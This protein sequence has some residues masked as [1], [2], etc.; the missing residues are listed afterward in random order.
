MKYQKASASAA[1]PAT[2]PTTAP[3]MGPVFEGDE[4]G[5]GADVRSEAGDEVCLADAEAR[6]GADVCDVEAWVDTIFPSSMNFP[7]PSLQQSV[8][9]SEVPQ[10]RT[11]S[12]QVV[13]A[14]Y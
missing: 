12:A 10:Q 13:S 14:T 3:T 1:T 8:A 6:V 7:R 5:A 9:E 2:P 4:P 11:P